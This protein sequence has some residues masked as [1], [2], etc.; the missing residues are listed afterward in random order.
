MDRKLGRQGVLVCSLVKRS[1]CCWKALHTRFR[2]EIH[3][4]KVGVKL[5]E[6]ME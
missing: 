5:F 1:M 2:E 4:H 3:W 6:L